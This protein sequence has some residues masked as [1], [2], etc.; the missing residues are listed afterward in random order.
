[1][2]VAS[3]SSIS[4]VIPTYNRAHLITDA[5]DSVAAQSHA[6]DEIIVVDDGST[7][8]TESVVKSW[9]EKA[10]QGISVTYVRQENAGGNVARNH[11]IEEAKGDVIAFLDSDDVWA[12]E[13]LEKQIAVLKSNP[14]F[15]AV[16]CGVREVAIG[17]D[18]PAEVPVRSYPHG[19]LLDALLVSDVTAP[20]S[21][22]VIRRDVF[23]TAGCFDTS[24]QA[25]Q[26]WDMWIRI[27]K[28]FKIGAIPEALT[29]LR[30]HDGPRT[31]TDPTRE[32]KAYKTILAKYASLRA[33]KSFRI[34]QA[35]LASYYRRAGRVHYHHMD[36]PVQAIGYHMRSILTWPLEPDSYA[37]L[38]GIFLP[39]GLR[40][41][42]HVGWNRIFGRTFLSIKSH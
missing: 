34:R 14:A 20:T 12:V 9:G 7:D 32:L 6:V 3:P 13:K 10:G 41:R 22:Y 40:K 42:L 27:A 31:I 25:R 17:S 30:S 18:D 26:D 16:Y 8:D 33:T 29:D 23:K 2:E 39:A 24:L 37:A 38:L 28:N 4:V 1:M 11:G 15:G 21:C 36:A 35:A 19:D 5:L